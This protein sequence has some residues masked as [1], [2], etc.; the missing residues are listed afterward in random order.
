MY[1]KAYLDASLPES[2]VYIGNAYDYNLFY[3]TDSVKIS[4]VYIEN[5]YNQRLPDEKFFEVL[6]G[7]KKLLIANDVDPGNYVFVAKGVA[8]SDGRTLK[9]TSPFTCLLYTSRCV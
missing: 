9:T 8:E 7:Q 5:A 1:S 3:P 2:W 4:E 6:Q